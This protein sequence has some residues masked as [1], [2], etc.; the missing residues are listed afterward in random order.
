MA[1]TTL[2]DDAGLLLIT[3]AAIGHAD[4]LGHVP[5]D[6]R[7]VSQRMYLTACERCGSTA[8]VSGPRGGWRSGGAAL[9]ER[10]AA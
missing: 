6:W 1:I 4:R 8:W 10:C 3:A 2:P 5:G 7:R 9:P